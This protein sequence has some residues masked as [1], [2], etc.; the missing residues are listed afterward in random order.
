MT[1]IVPARA[2]SDPAPERM[3]P[4]ARTEPMWNR[5]PQAPVTSAGTVIFSHCAST[6][7]AAQ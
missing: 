7:T 2:A 4:N 3:P 1:S 5:S 6:S